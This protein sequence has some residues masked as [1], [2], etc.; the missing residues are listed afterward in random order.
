MPRPVLR[1]LPPRSGGVAIRVISRFCSVPYQARIAH[2][3]STAGDASARPRRPPNARDLYLFLTSLSF[4][5][6]ERSAFA[7]GVDVVFA[8]G[9]G[10]RS[11]SCGGG[12]VTAAAR[13]SRGGGARRVTGS[14]KTRTEV[15][16]RGARSSGVSSRHRSTR[17]AQVELESERRAEAPAA[18][19]GDEAAGG[20]RGGA[21][22]AGG[23]QEVGPGAQRSP[24]HPTHFEVRTILRLVSYLYERT[25]CHAWRIVLVL[26]KPSNAI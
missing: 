23:H 24:R 13:G 14:E 18:G 25:S 12:S 3:Q 1:T 26:A 22:R 19:G 11:G 10:Q 21:R 16:F 7:S 15:C 8:R 6:A 9:E 20:R 5:L 2:A 17:L 4:Q